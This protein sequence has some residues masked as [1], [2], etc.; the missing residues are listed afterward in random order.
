MINTV[1]PPGNVG[2]QNNNLYPDDN[3]AGNVATCKSDLAK[4]GHP[5]GITLTYMYPNDSSNT[6]VFKAI[7]ASLRQCGITLNGKA[8]PGS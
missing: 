2:Y 1:I 8:E 6:R 3:G 4:G 5:N 7:Q